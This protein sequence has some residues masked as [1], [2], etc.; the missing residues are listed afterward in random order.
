L[1]PRTP[2]S[3]EDPTRHTAIVG[4][5]AAMWAKLAWD[6]DVFRDIQV[7]YP[8][9]QQP[10]AYAAINVCIAASSLR[11]WAETAARS[12]ARASGPAFDKKGFDSHLKAAVPAQAMCEAIA[13]TAKHSRFADGEWPG[14]WVS[15]EWEEGDEDSP[16]GWV[17][18]HGG[19]PAVLPGLSVNQFGS[20]PETWWAH[21]RGLQLVEGDFQLPQWQQN[22]LRQ[23]F[24]RSSEID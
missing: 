2:R 3:G 15:L 12:K 7:G 1:A 16:P 18:R 10:L 19:E 6:V 17:L 23:M 20:L 24:G 5:V 9:E 14:G 13:N 22:K 21:L 11:N 4:D 8:H